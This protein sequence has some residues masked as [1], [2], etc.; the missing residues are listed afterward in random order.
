MVQV[1]RG[2]G[3]LYVDAVLRI[4]ALGN[5]GALQL[6]ADAEYIGN[7]MSALAVAAPA[8]LVTLQ[9]FA[10]LP[11]EQFAE[12]AGGAVTEGSA[13]VKV[14]RMLAGW[15]GITWQPPVPGAA[16]ATGMGASRNGEQQQPQDGVGGE[17]S[18][19]T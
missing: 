4:P 2:A 15:R 7:V 14:L 1:V 6:A 8:A 19:A 16:V 9:L 5:G 10:G 11:A 12:V 17:L 3:E 18:M 13:D